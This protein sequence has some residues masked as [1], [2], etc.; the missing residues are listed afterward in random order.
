[1]HIGVFGLVL[2]LH[3][4]CFWHWDGALLHVEGIRITPVYGFCV[5]GLRDI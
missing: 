2:V 4:L 3:C 1:M 5:Q